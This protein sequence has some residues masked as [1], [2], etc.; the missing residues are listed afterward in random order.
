MMIIIRHPHK[1]RR[2]L[3]KKKSS[4]MKAQVLTSEIVVSKD[5]KKSTY[6]M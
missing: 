5:N 4:K 2:E 6:Q 1:R 3:S